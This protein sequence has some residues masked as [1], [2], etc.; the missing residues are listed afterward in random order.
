ML[1][2]HYRVNGFTD[3]CFKTE[4]GVIFE[5]FCEITENFVWP[6][7]NTSSKVDSTVQSLEFKFGKILRI[8]CN[9]GGYAFA[10]WCFLNYDHGQGFLKDISFKYMILY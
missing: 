7:S 9:E 4:S 10:S 2:S 8:T 1:A 5:G 3:L 6:E